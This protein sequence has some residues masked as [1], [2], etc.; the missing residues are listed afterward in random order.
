MATY[1]NKFLLTHKKLIS[2][3]SNSQFKIYIERNDH[4]EYNGKST[5]TIIY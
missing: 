3:N 5:L 2:V 4:N 1:K